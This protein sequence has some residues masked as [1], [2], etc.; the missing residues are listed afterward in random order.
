MKSIVDDR[1]IQKSAD[2]RRERE[3]ER[4]RERVLGD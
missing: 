3:R 1:V 4:E 2:V